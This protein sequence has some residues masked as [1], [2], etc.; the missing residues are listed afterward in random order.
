M[1]Y[2]TTGILNMG[3]HNPKIYHRLIHGPIPGATPTEQGMANH[4]GTHDRLYHLAGGD[5][6][7]IAKADWKFV[8]DI[9]NDP[10]INKMDHR[11]VAAVTAITIKYGFEKNPW[12]MLYN[13]KDWLVRKRK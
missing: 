13:G 11:V 10:N 2:G 8:R 3:P 12:L 6:V 4:S 7:Q 9:A 1:G 5:P